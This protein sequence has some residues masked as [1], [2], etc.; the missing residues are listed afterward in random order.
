MAI[1]FL[2]VAWFLTGIAFLIVIA[3]QKFLYYLPRRLIIAISFEEAI[4]IRNDFSPMLVQKEQ[5][6]LGKTLQRLGLSLALVRSHRPMHKSEKKA[7]S[8][9]CKRY[10]YLKELILTKD[11]SIFAI[12]EPHL[13]QIAED[14]RNNSMP[15]FAED[16]RELEW[17][18]E[19]LTDYWEIR[20]NYLGI[21]V[22]LTLRKALNV[23]NH[24]LEKLM[25]FIK[26]TG[27]FGLT[28][29]LVVGSILQYFLPR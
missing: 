7:V 25:A 18:L 22:G 23:I 11:K 27:G 14:F 4:R 1:G 3:I 13:R 26:T 15:K 29:S 5:E 21:R 19:R 8:D 24:G 6:V 20:N 28:I 2:A 17:T 9:L 10:P 16:Y 12:L